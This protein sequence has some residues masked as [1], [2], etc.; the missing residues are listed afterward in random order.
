MIPFIL[1][2]PYQ[3]IPPDRGTAWPWFLKRVLPHY[4][5]FAWGIH[6]VH[7]HGLEHLQ[8]SIAAG[9]SIVLAPNH[10]RLSDPFVIGMLAWHVPRYFYTM[11][12][13]HLFKQSKFNR[14]LMRRMGAYSVYR[15]GP[16]KAAI[17]ETVHNIVDGKRLTVLYPEGVLSRTNDHV[18]ELR[19]GISFIAR[20]AAKKALAQGKSIAIH[21]VGIR[22]H[23]LGAAEQSAATVLDRL[24]ALFNFNVASS[25]ASACERYAAL[26]WEILRRKEK[27][28]IGTIGEGPLDSRLHA[29][30]EHL[31]APLESKWLNKV[32][33]DDAPSR[34]KRLRLCMVP[35]LAYRRLDE[36][37]RDAR[38]QELAKVYL[39]QQLTRY[40]EGDCDV[41]ETERWLEAVERLEE[42]TTDKATLHRP[43]AAHVAIGEAMDPPTERSGDA[44]EQFSEALRV[45]MQSLLD[46][47]SPPQRPRVE[48]AVGAV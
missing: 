15:E 34:V 45:R 35:D 6:A 43:W 4:L 14:F 8:G 21:P 12:S 9:R 47:H 27:E 7:V 13:W 37:Q 33:T 2:E 38:W 30:R 3:F 25:R 26:A 36:T 23:F 42:D 28:V 31:L 1:E 24:E 10:S 41:N 17:Q 11:A 20:I 46:E 22:Y 18:G 32:F 40:R 48:Q 16:D 39:A 5:R 44:D 29:L 19:E